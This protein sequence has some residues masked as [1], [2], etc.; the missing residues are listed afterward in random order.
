MKCTVLIQHQKAL[1]E[2]LGLMPDTLLHYQI[3]SRVYGLNVLRHLIGA[4]HRMHQS[5]PHRHNLIR[6]SIPKSYSGEANFLSLAFPNNLEGLA[7]LITATLSL[8]WQRTHTLNRRW[9]NVPHNT[10]IFLLAKPNGPPYS[11]FFHKWVPLRF[12]DVN[13]R[14]CR[15]IE[16][17]PAVSS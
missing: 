15:D 3:S 17:D 1:P 9:D 2:K 7:R 6:T 5:T 12:E 10:H 11:L 14:G 13:P 8:R 16:T 4:V